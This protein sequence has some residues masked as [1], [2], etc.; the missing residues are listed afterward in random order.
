[1]KVPKT[2]YVLGAGFSKPAGAPSQE[3]ILGV[4][5]R[6][7]PVQAAVK[8]RRARFKKFLT[9]CLGVP[10]KKI[11][12]LSLE[13]IYTPIDRCLVD[14]TSFKG[15][16]QG[17]L[18]QLR[19]D[20]EF[21][22]SEAIAHCFSHGPYKD[23]EYPD[24]FARHLTTIAAHRATLAE[25]TR[26]KAAKEY[27]PF[28]I[29]SLNWDIL[30]DN[31]INQAIESRSNGARNDYG[32]FGVV[33]YCCYISSLH[34]GEWRIRS[35]LWTL[36]CRGYNIKLLKLHGS[37]NWLQCPNCQRLFVEFGE[38]STIRNSINSAPCRHCSDHGLIN[39]LQGSL[40]MPTFLKDLSNFQ[41]KL[42]W[43]NAG[44][45]L[46][47]AKN[48]V[49][50]GYSLPHSD[51]EFRQLMSRM[52]HKDTKIRV[53]LFNDKTPPGALRYQAECQRYAQFFAG[54][55]IDFEEDGVVAY[56][57]NLIASP[58]PAYLTTP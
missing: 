30:L 15:K 7:E 10:P 43:Q 9:K 57:N 27:D 39:L 56:V 1:M 13:D 36:G 22:V 35:G 37:M 48:L 26:A 49:F 32:P 17:E 52:V 14:G 21:L 29:I 40:V 20:I 2:V 38:K 33:D 4:I 46:L 18:E 28:S 55:S 23:R 16:H 47:E 24:K 45:E 34:E 53:V 6:K 3:E 44:V 8:K 25:E 54:H 5:F 12:S 50:I 51:F 58:M 11:S 19:S 42:I 31:A 41:I